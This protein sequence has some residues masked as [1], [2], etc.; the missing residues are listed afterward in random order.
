MLHNAIFLA[1]C[2]AT[3]EKENNCKLQSW[4]ATCHGLKTIH[5]IVAESRT[6]LYFVESLQSQKSCE[7]SCKEGIL[8]GA[9]YTA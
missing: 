1:V 5:A 2:L 3:L 4:A 6:D 9:S 8:H 7:T